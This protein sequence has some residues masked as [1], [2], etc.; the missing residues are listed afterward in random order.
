MGEALAAIIVSA[1]LVG[2]GLALTE[3]RLGFGTV[4]HVGVGLGVVVFVVTAVVVLLAH[5]ESSDKR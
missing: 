2:A 5:R 1:V 4:A 3:W